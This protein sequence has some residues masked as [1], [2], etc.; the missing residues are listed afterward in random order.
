MS[1]PNVARGSPDRFGYEWATYSEI[2]P[3][4]RGQLERWLG[5]MGLASFSGK[6]VLD[7]GC[8]MGRNPYWMAQ[9]GAK[10]VLAVDV[11]DQ[12]LNAAHRNLDPLPNAKVEKHSVY[13]LD[14]NQLGT[15]DRVTCIGVLHHLEDPK[16]ALQSLWSCVRAGGDLVLWCYAT[17]GNRLI[18]PI[19]QTCRWFGARLPLP[20]THAIA[21]TITVFSWPVIKLFPFR[22][23]YYARL[24]TL[25][26]GNVKSIIFDQMLPHI[27]N[28][29][30]KEEMEQ[31]LAPLAGNLHLE[32]VQGNSWHVRL[33]KPS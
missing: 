25:S 1:E 26:F 17:E 20:V 11:D 8:G 12:S 19:I 23:S 3:E 24:K 28:Y 27:A 9:A 14:P 2:L 31:L 5:S 32:F 6:E 15:F 22:T 7:V 13:D 21:G 16:R 30:T 4:S 10:R 29:W 18:L 33:E